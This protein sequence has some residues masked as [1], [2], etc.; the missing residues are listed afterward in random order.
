MATDDFPYDDIEPEE[1]AQYH[2][3]PGPADD[4]T[5]TRFAQAS[6]IPE[7][8]VT[9]EMLAN[10]TQRADSWL[11]Y[12]KGLGQLGFSPADTLT[13]DNVGS[14]SQNY[15]ISTEVNALET[16][17]LIVP[18]DPPVMYYT[19]QGEWEVAAANARTGDKFWEYQM[20]IDETVENLA[21]PVNRGAAVWQDKIYVAK[22]SAEL[23]ALN[24]Y[25][26]EREW[27][28][29]LVRDNQNTD[30][31]FLTQAPVVYDGQVLIGQSSDYAE[32]TTISGV[33]AQTGEISWQHSTA[34]KDEWVGD[35]WEFASNA[36]WMSPAVDAQ[37]NTAFFSVGNPDPYLNGL[38]RPGPNRDSCS[39]LAVDVGSGNIRWKRQISPH[40]L[41]DYDVHMT[42]HVYDLQVGGETRRVVSTIW[43]AGWIYVFDVETGQL[44]TRSPPIT[45]QDGNAFLTL[46]GAGEENAEE[47]FPPVNGATEWP[48]DTYSPQTGFHYSGVIE[49]GQK[50]WY[51]P[52][53]AYEDYNRDSF[54]RGGGTKPVSDNENSASVVAVD[55][56]S[57][58]I[59]WEFDLEDVNPAWPASRLF[60]GG[61][62]STAGNLVFHGS[63]AGNVYALN[64]E[65][66]D[67]VW[68]VQ[69][70][71]RVES[72]PIVWDDPSSETQHVTV[73]VDG[74]IVTYSGSPEG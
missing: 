17:P 20:Q 53:W 24:R 68:K 22:P 49:A 54:A 38:V 70:G 57:Q 32:Y 30:R 10:D 21:L 66:G 23:V 61:T 29:D 19:V 56:T 45:R 15:S 2:D 36:S 71:N 33:D 67:R 52:D 59:A 64:A 12:N 50:V 8:A 5:V 65:T 11:T 7:L 27:E 31:V 63:S 40:D 37:S 46:P 73:P 72:S 60:T 14:L 58:D 41:W 43:K 34:P 69:E 16:N 62:T 44:I 1:R 74:K 9:D 39:L 13:A 25:T 42:P 6:N 28:T 18:S 4:P 47:L 48:P 3:Q 51:D 35:T 26:G 55:A